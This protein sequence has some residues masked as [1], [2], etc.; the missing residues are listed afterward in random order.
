MASGR[1]RVCRCTEQFPCN[2]PCAWFDPS[3]CTS[4]ALV[5]EA[6]AAWVEGAHVAVTAALWREVHRRRIEMNR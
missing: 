3:L 1:C 4:C 5:V 6:L 2:P